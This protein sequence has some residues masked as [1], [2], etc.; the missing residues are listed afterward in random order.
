MNS[1]SDSA[2][3]LSRMVMTARYYSAPMRRQLLI[4]AALTVML[5][6]LSL[7]VFCYVNVSSAILSGIVAIILPFMFYLS[8]V[9]LANADSPVLAAM[10]PARGIEKFLV[11]LGYCLVVVPVVICGVWALLW[12]CVHSFVP[13]FELWQGDSD[14]RF[15]VTYTLLYRGLNLLAPWATVLWVVMGCRTS[16]MA[17]ALLAGICSLIGL[18]TSGV[19]V[20]LITVY[21]MARND[22]LAVLADS[23]NANDMLERMNHGSDHFLYASIV[24]IYVVLFLYSAWA[25]WRS[26]KLVAG[27]QI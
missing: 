5:F 4:Y 19:V 6:F 23:A 17:K 25:L 10:L 20:G 12:L 3:S 2:L 26:Y 1:A 14:V 24:V 7:F 27:R 22:A 15:S 16:P 18:W 9:A 8:P 13:D 21:I 11:I